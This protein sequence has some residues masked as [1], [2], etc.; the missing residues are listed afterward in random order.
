MWLTRKIVVAIDFGEPSEAAADLALELAQRFHVPVVLVHSY[1]APVVPYTPIAVVPTVDHVRALEWTARDALEKEAA[2]LF[3]KG[4]EVTTELRTGFALDEILAAAKDLDAGLIVMGT[5]GRRGLPRAL[6][7]SV[8]E[9]V[10]RLSPVPVLTVHAGSPDPE[11]T[12]SE[13]VRSDDLHSTER[14][15]H[16]NQ[17]A[18]RP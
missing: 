8:A 14:V 16:A 5:H 2:R 12:V 6:L 9:K 7:G 1:L 3:G 10:V 15:R 13:R 4:V 11:A 18:H 17:Q